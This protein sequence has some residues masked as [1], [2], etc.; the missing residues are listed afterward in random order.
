MIA[1]GT[2]AVTARDVVTKSTTFYVLVLRMTLAKH[3]MEVSNYVYILLTLL[4][5]LF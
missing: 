5:T 1:G 3:V 2:H 4:V